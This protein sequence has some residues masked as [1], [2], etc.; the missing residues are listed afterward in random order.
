MPRKSSST[1]EKARDLLLSFLESLNRRPLE[2]LFET[3]FEGKT[4]ADLKDVSKITIQKEVVCIGKSRVDLLFS[5]KK[6]VLC[7]EVKVD[8]VEQLGQY[9]KYGDFFISQ[10]KS[11][12]VAGLINQF[13]G[14]GGKNNS[15]PFFEF[16]KIPRILWFELLAKFSSELSMT[17]EFKQFKHDLLLLNPEIGKF[18]RPQINYK[19]DHPKDCDL[20][21]SKNEVLVKFYRDLN[22]RFIGWSSAPNKYG[23]APYELH[24]G[25]TSW[26]NLF[27][28]SSGR[29]I[30]VGLNQ[31]RE[32]KIH[33]E[34]YFALSV[35]LWNRSWFANESWFLKNR[36]NVAAYFED[37]GFKIV[38]N[39]GSSWHRNSN[40]LPPYETVHGLKF[41]NAFGE[42]HFSLVESDYRRIGW[43]KSLQ[44]LEKE[45]RRI[46][47]VIDRLK[48]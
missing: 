21:A 31:L 26:A 32:G 15:E 30:V 3:I 10:G 22:N 45:V 37:V 23:N 14:T 42:H 38:R 18:E 43:E 48:L 47:A 35:M 40:W 11:T 4:P 33:D 9:L 41:V 5:N 12:F 27:C 8:A 39:E 24:L 7:I 13:K 20:L 28:E 19:A 29:R 34:P 6:T 17:K 36:K 2:L 1:E 16:L 46:G 25:Q 44:I